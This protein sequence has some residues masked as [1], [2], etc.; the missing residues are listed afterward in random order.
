MNWVRASRCARL[1]YQEWHTIS[2]SESAVRGPSLVVM[3]V[4]EA[5]LRAELQHTHTDTHAHKACVM[6]VPLS[7]DAHSTAPHAEHTHNTHTHTHTRCIEEASSCKGH[8]CCT[9]P[10]SICY[11][12]YIYYST[13]WNSGHLSGVWDISIHS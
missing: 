13:M 9:I 7:S 12:H 5:A 11:H 8:N 2:V 6:V 10:D 3:E 1:Q 4:A